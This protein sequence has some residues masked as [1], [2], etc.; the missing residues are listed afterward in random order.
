MWTPWGFLWML[1]WSVLL[2]LIVFALW[3]LLF[4]RTGTVGSPE[5][6][7]EIF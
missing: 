1:L 4:G 3:R 5:S 2:V 7:V 6:A